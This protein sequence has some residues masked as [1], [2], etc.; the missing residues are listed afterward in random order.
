MERKQ[1]WLCHLVSLVHWECQEECDGNVVVDSTAGRTL[2]PAISGPHRATA[3][4][5]ALVC[6]SGRSPAVKGSSH[7]PQ[8]IEAGPRPGA[9]A[10]GS[11]LDPA[12]S[13]ADGFAFGH[14][15]EQ[16]PAQLSMGLLPI[17]VIS[18]SGA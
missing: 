13:G 2:Y 14:C 5:P 12:N 18:E 16:L 10:R 8:S 11:L 9:Q 15:S 3:L 1:E 4:L 7:V 17:P 6:V